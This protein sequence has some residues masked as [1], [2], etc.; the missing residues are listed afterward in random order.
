[1]FKPIFVPSAK[2]L[3][4]QSPV[5]SATS[6]ATE[7]LLFKTSLTNLFKYS[8]LGLYPFTLIVLSDTVIVVTLFAITPVNDILSL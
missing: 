6:Q 1:M 8:A 2:G 3:I 7:S 4:I 5:P